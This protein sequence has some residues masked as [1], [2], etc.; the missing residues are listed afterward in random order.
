VLKVVAVEP[1]R[2]KTLEEVRDQLKADLAE[3][4]AIDEV[5]ALST[6]LEDTLGGGAS[7][8]EAA[9]ALGLELRRVEAIDATGKDRSGAPVA[10]LPDNLA[11]TVFATPEK[12]ESAL[13][14]S[15]RDTFYLVRVDAVTPAGVKP[16][17]E[18]HDQVIA[19][20]KAEQRATRARETASAIA[21]AA[22]SG[23]ALAA[24]A[25]AH[26]LRLRTTP[27]VVRASAGRPEGVPPAI[28][29]AAFAASQGEVRVVPGQAG[30]YVVRVAAISEADPGSDSAGVE[31]L[32]SDLDAQA[33]EDALAQ[34]SGGIR[35]E[36]PVTMNPTVLEQVF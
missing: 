22:R 26:G 2:E 31:A 20:W 34:F 16:L 8:E 4:K 24:A 30:S 29:E 17:A 15:G 13:T 21:E 28:V 33:Q 10:G 18:V 5:Y 9:A 25:E 14:E 3:E 36:F 35:K 1:A 12:S 27:P 19:A 23:T 6:R 11:A 32:R 7:L